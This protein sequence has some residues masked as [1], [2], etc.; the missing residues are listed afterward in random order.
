M[1]KIY[2]KSAAYVLR[3]QRGKS[4]CKINHDTE[5]S[6]PDDEGCIYS[7]D[8]LNQGGANSYSYSESE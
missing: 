4:G 1:N 3:S 5:D 7:I 2:Q 8:I 6:V